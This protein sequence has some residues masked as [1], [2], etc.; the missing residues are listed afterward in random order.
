MSAVTLNHFLFVS[1]GLFSIGLFGLIARK[2]LLIMLMSIELMF[3]AVNLSF[4]AFS[5]FY[6][7]P[8][9]QI[10]TF[11]VMTIAAAEAG[12]GLALI[13]LISRTFSK[14]DL[15]SLEKAESS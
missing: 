1:L 12:V 13:V 2:N 7:L 3:N 4:I 8:D 11:F 14:I 9:G 5:K 6:D 10:I 15:K